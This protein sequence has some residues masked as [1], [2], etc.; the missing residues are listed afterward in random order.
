M[1]VASRTV[2]GRKSWKCIAGEGVHV[3]EERK[4][5][6]MVVY[7]MGRNNGASHVKITVFGA[8]S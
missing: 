1:A 7:K 6:I 5:I 8:V 2:P 3:T 4:V